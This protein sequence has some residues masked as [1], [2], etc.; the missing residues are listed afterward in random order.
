MPVYTAYVCRS[1]AEL[2]PHILELYAPPRP[3]GEPKVRVADVTWGKG[4][5][6]ANVDITQYDF[7]ASDIAT[8]PEARH[9]FRHLPHAEASF[10]L[11]VL[12]PP[13]MHTMTNANHCEARYRN[14]ETTGNMGHDALVQ[15]YL[16][17]M[18]EAHR[19]LKEGGLLFV[20]T[21]DEIECGKQRW[22]HIE[23]MQAAEA[24]GLECLD[25]FVMVQAGGPPVQYAEQLHARKRHI[26]MVVM[27]KNYVFDTTNRPK[28][29]PKMKSIPLD[30]L[31]AD[32]VFR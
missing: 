31:F 2:I 24:L 20:K 3:D 29:K 17:G 18:S 22:T 26:Y 21:Q 10:D 1:N 16:D 9:D 13:Y 5:F 12:D 28:R 32:G 25:L 11:I 7:Y 15:L 6:W 14:V 8:V 30:E 19:V 4:T 23:V 27:G